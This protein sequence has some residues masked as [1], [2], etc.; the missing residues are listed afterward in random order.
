MSPDRTSELARVA[1]PAISRR[2]VVVLLAAG[3]ALASLAVLLPAL[4]D[5][6]DTWSRL[7]GGDGRWLLLALGFEALSFGHIVLFRAVSLEG[8]ARVGL[9]AS[10]EITLAGHAATRLFAS[11]GAGGI[12]LTAWALRPRGSS[13]VRSPRA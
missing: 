1:P 7:R 6:G 4:A 2:G 9:R 10:T 8:N 5:A 13:A 11:G 3:A 12:V